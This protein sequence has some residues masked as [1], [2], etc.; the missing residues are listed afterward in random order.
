MTQIWTGVGVILDLSRTVRIFDQGIWHCALCKAR[1]HCF[2]VSAG[3]SLSCIPCANLFEVQLISCE[4]RSQTGCRD[5]FL[6]I[7]TANL[8]ECKFFN[9][10]KIG[11]V[12]GNAGV[13]L[14]YIGKA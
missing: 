1:E 7:F 12:L 2:F 13:L 10:G 11:F 6:L 4:M 3:I 14:R 5:V 9:D 8:Y